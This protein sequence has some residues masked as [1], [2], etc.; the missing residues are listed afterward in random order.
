MGVVHK[1]VGEI[2]CRNGWMP[3][4]WRTRRGRNLGISAVSKCNLHVLLKPRR[5]VDFGI[6]VNLIFSS[7]MFVFGQQSE[8]SKVT[9]Q[10]AS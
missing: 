2:C 4:D 7:L 9:T 6:T 5:E 1:R 3:L 8:I 10:N